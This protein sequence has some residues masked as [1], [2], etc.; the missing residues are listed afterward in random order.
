MWV[1]EA[2]WWQFIHHS[3]IFGTVKPPLNQSLQPHWTCNQLFS[4]NEVYSYMYLQV[5]VVTVAFP[6]T[7]LLLSRARICISASHTREDLEQAL[8]V[9]TPPFRTVQL[10]Y[11]FRRVNSMVQHN[12]LSA[13]LYLMCWSAVEQVISEV[14]DMCHLKY[15]PVGMTE[16]EKAL[17]TEKEKSL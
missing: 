3:G 5:A 7:P 10:L 1:A 14:C 4:G 9:T 12:T 2:P 17:L 8:Q 15:F 16:K 11:F 13:E 6:A